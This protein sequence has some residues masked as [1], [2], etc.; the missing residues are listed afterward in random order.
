MIPA[1]IAAVLSPF[2]FVLMFFSSHFCGCSFVVSLPLLDFS[3][4]KS[5]IYTAEQVGQFGN[6]SAGRVV[7]W[8]L[9]VSVNYTQ[10][11][12]Q[13]HHAY[14]EARLALDKKTQI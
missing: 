2:I 9:C 4:I 10:T 7:P 6:V 13:S 3:F 14:D 8:C 5:C 1:R 12:R 11:W